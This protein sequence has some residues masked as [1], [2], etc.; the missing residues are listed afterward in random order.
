MVFDSDR[1][2]GSH[3]FGASLRSVQNAYKPSAFLNWLNACAEEGGDHRSLPE[4]VRA[5]VNSAGS[6][7]GLALETKKCYRRWLARYARFA[8][9]EHEVMREETATRFLTSVV[10][11]EDCAY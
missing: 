1:P 4:R 7:R 5:A 3:P 8:G 2:S 11:D 6:I 9:D 10:D